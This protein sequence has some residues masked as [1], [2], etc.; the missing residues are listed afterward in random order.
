MPDIQT[1][2]IWQ[3]MV[4]C[5]LPAALLLLSSCSEPL[6]LGPTVAA[7]PAPGKPF[8]V[9]QEDQTLCQQYAVGEVNGPS[10]AG[11]YSLQNA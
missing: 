3:R 2:G 6:P 4:V 5:T 11:A 8:E 7:M 1:V 10:Q 9:F